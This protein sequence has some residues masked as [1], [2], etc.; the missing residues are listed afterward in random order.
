MGAIGSTII[1]SRWTGDL[2][3][4]STGTSGH[5]NVRSDEKC[6][7]VTRAN[8]SRA[9]HATTINYCTVLAHCNYTAGR[10]G[11]IGTAFFSVVAIAR[12]DT[13]NRRCCTLP[14][15][16]WIFRGKV[17]TFLS[18]LRKFLRLRYCH[19]CDKTSQLHRNM[20]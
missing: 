3:T 18:K 13:P 20:S 12:G 16:A 7:D 15:S 14:I 6:A 5:F 4:H 17:R 11:V 2:N 1:S 9:P 19:P 10:V 8:Y